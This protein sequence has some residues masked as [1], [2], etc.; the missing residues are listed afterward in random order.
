VP[1]LDP[2]F[3]PRALLRALTE[4]GVD[5]V[6]IGGIAVIFHGAVRFTRDLDVVFARDTANLDAMGRALTGLRATLRGVDEELPFVADARALDG[7]ELLTLST[8]AGP[9]DVHERPKG[10]PEYRTLRRRALRVEI[11][12]FNVLVAS[13]D[14]LIAMKRSAGRPLDLQDLELLEEVRR[15]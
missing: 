2:R 12:G 1:E 14:D 4:H 13:I 11:E 7:V 6:V 3:T 9:L 8:D 5:F 10:A 15:R